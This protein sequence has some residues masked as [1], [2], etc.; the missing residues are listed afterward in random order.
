MMVCKGLCVS[1][2]L[3]CRDSDTKSVC[4]SF[5]RKRQHWIFTFFYMPRISVDWQ[6]DGW[7]KLTIILSKKGNTNW[8][9][10]FVRNQFSICRVNLEEDE[11]RSD[12]CWPS[13]MW[14]TA[15]FDNKDGATNN[16]YVQKDPSL[17]AMH[18][19]DELKL[20][21]V[22]FVIKRTRRS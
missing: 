21:W 20:T 2:Q 18:I 4:L 22:V 3:C 19:W 10:F 5:P 13:S 15:A 7:R 9:R 8:N 1:H 6:I 12:T 16:Y 17:I 14:E 11:E